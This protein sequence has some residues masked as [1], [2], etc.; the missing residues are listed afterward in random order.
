ML[1]AVLCVLS[2]AG[3]REFKKMILLGYKFAQRLDDEGAFERFDMTGVDKK[4][5][6]L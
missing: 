2:R 4:A 6:I 1:K 3:C 5:L